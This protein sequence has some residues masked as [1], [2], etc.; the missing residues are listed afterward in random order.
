MKQKKNIDSFF[1]ERFNGFEQSPPPEVWNTIKSQLQQ[2]K[3]DRKVIPFWFKIAGVAA[4]LALLFTLGNKIFIP[5]SHTNPQVTQEEYDKLQDKENMRGVNS[6]NEGVASEEI[7]KSKEKTTKDIQLVLEE[8]RS[9]DKQTKNSS[10]TSDTNNENITFKNTGDVAVSQKKNTGNNK[11]LVDD[12]LVLKDGITEQENNKDNAVVTTTKTDKDN[13]RVINKKDDT[14][15]LDEDSAVAVSEKEEDTKQSIFDAIEENNKEDNV[16]KKDIPKKTWE[17]T[18]NFAPV[19]YSSLSSGSSIDPSFSDNPQQG[20]ITFSYGVQVSYAISKKVHL[21]TGVNTVDLRYSTG[22][23]EVVTAP[24]SI[25]LKSVD[26][27]TR[28]TVV[29][30][31]DKGTFTKPN[32]GM[33]YDNI[34]PKSTSGNAKLFQDINYFEIPLELQYALLNKKLGVNLIGGFS[35]LFLANDEVYVREGNYK[36]TLG[37]ANNLSKT[38]FTGNVGLGINYRFSKRFM[39]NV[40]PMFKY[41]LNAYTDSSI[42][43]KPYYIGVYT[44]FRFKF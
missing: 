26:Y 8:K 15:I 25:A 13:T 14:I 32:G 1:K 38:S 21:R 44:G 7:E 10:I 17:V 11:S 41:Q 6:T 29:T 22:D 37:K 20:D 24:V 3:A 16:V 34:S 36:E 12:T 23:I 5:S 9:L 31:A 30:V 35:T 42:D 19:Y 2:E 40:E 18:P 39:F 33:E 4:L 27:G 43:Y 28:Q